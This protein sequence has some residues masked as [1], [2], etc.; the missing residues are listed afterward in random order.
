M[1]LHVQG[2][3]KFLAKIGESNMTSQRLFQSL[4]FREVSRSTVFREVTF[5]LDVSD[6]HETLSALSERI[7]MGAYDGNL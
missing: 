6:I 4:K 2:I 3:R 7:S 1:M 5:G